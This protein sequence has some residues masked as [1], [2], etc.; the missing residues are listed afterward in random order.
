VREIVRAE[1]VPPRHRRSPATSHGPR[2]SA[3]PD[4]RSRQRV[5]G[6]AVVPRTCMNV[7][8]SAIRTRVTGLGYSTNSRCRCICESHNQE[9][10]DHHPMLRRNRRFGSESQEANRRRSSVALLEGSIPGRNT[11]HLI[12]HDASTGRCRLEQSSSEISE[13][14]AC[15]R[16]ETSNMVIGR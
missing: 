16:P 2:G 4:D 5:R 11:F 13:T 9:R 6:V 1:P 10:V 14:S 12:T 7:G 3:A 15:L 8:D